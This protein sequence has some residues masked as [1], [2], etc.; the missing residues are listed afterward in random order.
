MSALSAFP[1]AQ[2]HPR[3]ALYRNTLKEKY[4]LSVK[5]FPQS[6]ESL[7][8]R[9][10]KEKKASSSINPIV[11]FYN[12]I[13]IK[14][15]VTAGAFDLDEL[16][17]RGS[18]PL[19]LRMS[20]ESDTFLAL[21]THAGEEPELIPEGELSYAQGNTVLTRHLA[22]RQAVHG[23]VTPQTKDVVFV[24]EVLCEEKS[25][26]K[27]ALAKAVSKDFID[28]LDRYFDVKSTVG[29]LGLDL[30]KLSTNI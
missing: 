19:E 13:S 24:S 5:K 10:L 29:I 20:T 28:G 1:N 22:W 18:M 11:D 23:L 8:K 14:H 15:G 9:L 7:Y 21:G 30:G 3:I 25:D 6:N 17:S 27:D 26:E 2:S 4:G 12:S 16:K